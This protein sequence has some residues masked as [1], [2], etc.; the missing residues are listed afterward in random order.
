M[1]SRQETFSVSKDPFFNILNFSRERNQLAL[2]NISDSLDSWMEFIRMDRID[3][4][5]NQPY[6]S[7]IFNSTN[8][9][10]TLQ[11]ALQMTESLHQIAHHYFRETQFGPNQYRLVDF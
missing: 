9:N 8:S 5:D 2:Q 1:V 7:I 11:E 6:N 10:D 4:I 3:L